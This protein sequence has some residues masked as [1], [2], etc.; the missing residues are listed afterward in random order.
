MKCEKCGARILVMHAGGGKMLPV[1]ERQVTYEPEPDGPFEVLG[2][3]KKLERGRL[4]V[5]ASKT[6]YVL[7]RGVCTGRP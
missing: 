2:P 6:G 5:G 1:N 3:G 4:I 7:H